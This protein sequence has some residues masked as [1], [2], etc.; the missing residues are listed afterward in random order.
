MTLPDV[1]GILAERPHLELAGPLLSTRDE[2]IFF[3]L[4]PKHLQTPELA[5]YHRGKFH[6]HGPRPDF[7]IAELLNAFSER[8]T[9]RILNVL[10]AAVEM[11]VR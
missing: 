9:D 5:I 11:T 1:V 6:R 4:D 2:R 3:S 8:D 10:R 7:S